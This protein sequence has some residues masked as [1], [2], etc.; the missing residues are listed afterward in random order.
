MEAVGQRDSRRKLE[1]EGKGPRVDLSATISALQSD[2]VGTV[3]GGGSSQGV[4]STTEDAE[5]TV[6]LEL[7][8]LV[9]AQ[10]TSRGKS[11]EEVA[12]A[13]IDRLSNGLAAQ[14]PRYR[15]S[16]AP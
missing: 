15:R 12:E 7:E 4:T 16:P 9:I 6:F 3:E 2:I 5:T 8:Q 1:V 11:K 14:L 10:A 13:L